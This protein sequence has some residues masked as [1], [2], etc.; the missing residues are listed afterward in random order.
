[1]NFAMHGK[2]GPKV[3][4]VGLV[5]HL[6]IETGL[7]KVRP[8][9]RRSELKIGR[10][11]ADDLAPAAAPTDRQQKNRSAAVSTPAPSIGI[12][13]M[14]TSLSLVRSVLGKGS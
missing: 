9:I 10:D 6:G 13:P 7:V 5:A 3:S 4:C 14:I 1:M 8:R 2:F 12:S 11:L